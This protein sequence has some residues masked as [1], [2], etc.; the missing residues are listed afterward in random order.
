M[1]SG[2]FWIAL[3]YGV[4]VAVFC[5]FLPELQLVRTTGIKHIRIAYEMAFPLFGV[6][7]FSQLLAEDV[8]RQVLPWLRTLP[9][10]MWRLLLERWLIGICL[11]LIVYLLSLQAIDAY[12]LPLPA[13]ETLSLLAPTLVLSHL[14]LLLTIVGKNSVIGIAVSLFYWAFEL[15]S[16]GSVTRWVYLYHASYPKFGV[17]HDINRVLLWSMAA[18]LLALCFWAISWRRSVR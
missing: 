1:R 11:L 3:A 8:E 18:L 14:A 5:F 13:G 4:A 7:L 6:L 2:L 15:M 16:N 12:V 10:P 9:F 17:V